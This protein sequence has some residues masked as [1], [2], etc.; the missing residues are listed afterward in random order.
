MKHTPVVHVDCYDHSCPICAGGLFLCS[1]CGGA[2]GSLATECPGH[3]LNEQLHEAV[4][5]GEIDYV[6][7]RWVNGAM[8][9]H[10][11]ATYREKQRR[12]A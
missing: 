7:G 2:E 12:V 5:K 11:P 4:Y 9:K 8:S 1:V 10:T 3:Q 6:G